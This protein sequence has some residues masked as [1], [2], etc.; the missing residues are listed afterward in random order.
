MTKR[1]RGA[2][3]VLGTLSAFLLFPA[4][5]AEVELYGVIDVGM[6]WMHLTGDAPGTG[7]TDKLSMDTGLLSMSRFGV[8]GEEALS[9]GLRTGF[10]LENGFD[11][12]TGA[13]TQTG[14]LFGREAAL[15]LEGNFGRIVLGRM[16]GIVSGNGSY[17]IA[18]RITPLA[19][20]FS[21]Y[22]A[23]VE[24]VVS[25]ALDGYLDNA[26]LY[27]SPNMNGFT[28]YAQYSFGTGVTEGEVEGKSSAD[29]YA[30]LGLTYED[31]RNYAVLAVDSINYSSK[32]QAAV[33]DSFT[34]T[35][36]GNHDFGPVRGYFGGQYFNRARMRDFCLTTYSGL[37]GASTRLRGWGLTGGVDRA[38]LGGVML[39]GLSFMDARNASAPGAAPGFT[40]VKRAAASAGYFT[41][42]TKR[43]TFY[44]DAGVGRDEFTFRDRTVRPDYWR[45]LAGVRHAF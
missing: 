39:F 12:D 23:N 26:V 16:G 41:N 40:D 4:Q 17:C 27:R 38:M 22:N 28:A 29:R 30:A 10:V 32:D 24:A 6:S 19:P 25:Y 7:T 45:L 3:A 20:S 1:K 2:A 11:P 33:R 34:V 35:F 18:D 13:M 9:P 44:A 42:L 14:R 21:E 43:T 36:G 37:D 5:A 15:H 31:A 8:R